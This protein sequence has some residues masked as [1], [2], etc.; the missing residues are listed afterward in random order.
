MK[1][2]AAKCPK[3]NADIEVNE[4]LDKAICQYCGS[5]ILIEN[6]IQKHK[7]EITGTIKVDGIQSNKEKIE[8]ILNYLKIGNLDEATGI[9]DELLKQNPFDKEALSIYIQVKTAILNDVIDELNQMNFIKKRMYKDNIEDL[10]I[11]NDADD[12]IEKLKVVSNDYNE[13]INEYYKTRRNFEKYS[14]TK[15]KRDLIVYLINTIIL[16]FIF[17]LIINS[18]TV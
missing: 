8:I 3:C 12:L 6:A 5:T 14:Q 18:C 17:L 9:L 15:I 7:M 1:L 16:I 4:T 13:I 11:E 2:I 10:L